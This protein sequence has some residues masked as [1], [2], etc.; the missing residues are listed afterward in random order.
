MYVVA[1]HQRPRNRP[2][3][4]VAFR[5]GLA[6]IGLVTV[7]ALV[8][9]QQEGYLQTIGVGG[10][11]WAEHRAD[12]LHVQPEACLADV[13]PSMAVSKDCGCS[14]A[15]ANARTGVCILEMLVCRPSLRRFRRGV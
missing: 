12:R 14:R 13:S 15:K 1:A 6:S 5:Q 9:C 3:D 10:V 11:D 4:G 7:Y 2:A 8:D